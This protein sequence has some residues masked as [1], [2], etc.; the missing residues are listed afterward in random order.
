MPKINDN[1]IRELLNRDFLS[2]QERPLK[3]YT[4]GKILRTLNPRT[5]NRM[6]RRRSDRLSAKSALVEEQNKSALHLSIGDRVYCKMSNVSQG[7]TVRDYKI[8]PL[9]IAGLYTDATDKVLAV[10]LLYA[11]TKVHTIYPSELLIDDYETLKLMHSE[12]KPHKIATGRIFTVP[13][14]GEFLLYGNHNKLQP[15]PDDLWPDLLARQAAA[16]LFEKTSI[17][18]INC[19]PFIDDPGIVREGFTL[20]IPPEAVCKGAWLPC[21]P[22]G[23]FSRVDSEI[24]SP[25]EIDR[26]ISFVNSYF[27]SL[28]AAPAIY[29]PFS[30]WDQYP[31][32]PFLDWR[33][34]EALLGMSNV[35]VRNAFS[36]YY[37][38][39]PASADSQENTGPEPAA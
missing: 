38:Q 1:E 15:L 9:L 12:G 30:V 16:I 28:R 33:K 7:G 29:P 20:N 34:T 26:V 27:H 4:K 18:H 35:S 24:L 23:Q 10:D 6:H 37:G 25:N 31:K 36:L 2:S 17:D 5:A 13:A 11:T 14:N 22:G 32:R 3:A 21:L 8:R 39:K 19:A